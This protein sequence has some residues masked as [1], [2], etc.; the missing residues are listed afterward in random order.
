M[1]VLGIT[2]VQTSGEARNAD[3]KKVAAR[4]IE[5]MDGRG[6]VRRDKKGVR[7]IYSRMV[8]LSLWS[9]PRPTDSH[10][11]FSILSTM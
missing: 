4:Q 2:V 11:T 8:N 5:G 10:T 9:L 1:Y 6:R 7:R 3:R